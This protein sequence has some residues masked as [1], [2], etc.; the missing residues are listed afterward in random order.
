ASAHDALQVSALIHHRQVA[1]VVQMH[2]L[3]SLRQGAGWMYGMASRGH[4]IRSNT[5]LRLGP[6]PAMARRLKRPGPLLEPAVLVLQKK[7]VVADYAQHVLQ[8][9]DHGHGA[10]SFGE[11][12]PNELLKRHRL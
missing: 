10:V 12:Q 1:S 2:Q 9:I 3:G 11:D 6:S 7:V 4:Q 8:S 5:R